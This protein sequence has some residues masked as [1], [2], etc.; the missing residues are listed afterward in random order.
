MIDCFIKLINFSSYYET[1]SW[2]NKKFP[3]YL[4]IIVMVK[5]H[6]KP[7]ELFK[8]IKLIEIKSGKK[9]ILVLGRHFH[10]LEDLISKS[11]NNRIRYD[12][13]TNKIKVTEFPDLEINFFLPLNA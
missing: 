2:P 13:R 12:K 7:Y 6:L 8:I 1:H 5:T 9:P 11:E 4:N 3:K 10:D